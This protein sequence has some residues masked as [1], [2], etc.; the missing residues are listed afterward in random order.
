MVLYGVGNTTI[1]AVMM[2]Y[3]SRKVKLHDGIAVDTRFPK[4]VSHFRFHSGLQLQFI[5]LSNLFPPFNVILSQT[6]EPDFAFS[7]QRKK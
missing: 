1:V 7:D 3:C 2:Y 5:I 4:S 6:S